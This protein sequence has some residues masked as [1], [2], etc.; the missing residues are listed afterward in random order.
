M[1]RTTQEILTKGIKDSSDVSLGMKGSLL[2]HPSTVV[3]S[4]ALKEF[5]A[6]QFVSA[7]SFGSAGDLT[8][9]GDATYGSATY[10]AGM[11]IY[12]DVSMCKTDANT[13]VILYKG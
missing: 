12:G 3:A 6:V 7:G 11:I 9:N 13:T 1:A 4:S 10:P 5:I 2:V 8:I